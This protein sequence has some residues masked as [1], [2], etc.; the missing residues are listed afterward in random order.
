MD[1]SI[2]KLYGINSVQL[3]NNLV[4]NIFIPS[5]ML[6]TWGV[7]GFEVYIYLISVASTVSFFDFNIRT[8]IINRYQNLFRNDKNL[9]LNQK[10]LGWIVFYASFVTCLSVLFWCSGF[11]FIDN[12]LFYSFSLIMIFLLLQVQCGFLSELMRIWQLNISGQ[13]SDLLTN[14]VLNISMF[15]SLSVSFSLNQALSF[16]IIFSL[17]RILFLVR[18][19]STKTDLFSQFSVKYPSFRQAYSVCRKGFR[20]QV[21][22]IGSLARSSMPAVLSPYG[23]DTVSLASYSLCKTLSNVPMQIVGIMN[24]SLFHRANHFQNNFKKARELAIA[25]V[26]CA[27]CFIGMVATFFLFFFSEIGDL[28]L[29]DVSGILDRYVFFMLLT[30]AGA[31]AI[32]NAIAM[33]FVATNQFHLIAK[34][35]NILTVIIVFG[36]PLTVVL[37]GLKGFAM[38]IM[39]VDVFFLLSLGLYGLGFWNQNES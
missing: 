36:T 19:I 5:L 10:L 28:W 4:K 39:S 32:S 38:F 33:H 12:E 8:I 29:G 35:F 16:W 11:L 26:L 7:A 23:V 13:L 34:K 21:F 1:K 14:I 30:S 31:Y 9:V 37:F 27:L 18:M 20:L 24:N 17:F 22:P 3:L 15:V 25:H 6:K 2:L